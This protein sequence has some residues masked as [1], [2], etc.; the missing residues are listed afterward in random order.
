MD[1]YPHEFTEI[2]VRNVILKKKT[3]NSCIIPIVVEMS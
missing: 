3:F 1:T 2:Q